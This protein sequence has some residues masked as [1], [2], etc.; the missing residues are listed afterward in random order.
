MLLGDGVLGQVGALQRGV[1]VGFVHHSVVP[2]DPLVRQL[3]RF[4]DLGVNIQSEELE[5]NFVVVDV[6]AI[7]S[8]FRFGSADGELDLIEFGF[9]V[10]DPGLADRLVQ[11]VSQ[12]NA[13]HAATERVVCSPSYLERSGVAVRVRRTPTAPS[14]FRRPERPAPV[15]EDVHQ[16]PSDDEPPEC[17]ARPPGDRAVRHTRGVWVERH[18]LPY[19]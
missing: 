17:A 11:L 19:R 3:R 5:G 9:A 10:V 1:R 12:P 6:D 15:E 13:T 7:I 18:R 2:R 14:S 16:I 4:K 8:S